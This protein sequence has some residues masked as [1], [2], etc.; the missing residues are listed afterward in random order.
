MIRQSRVGGILLGLTLC[1]CYEAP[2][3]DK[4]PRPSVVTMFDLDRILAAN[5]GEA[6]LPLPGGIPF[7][8]RFARVGADLIAKVIPAFAEGK[9]AAYITTEYWNQ[10]PEVWVQ[11]MY[12]LTTGRDATGRWVQTANAPIFSIA[13]VGH[14]G[15]T[16][17][18]YSPYWQVYYV[19]VPATNSK[20][21]RS[22]REI[23]ADK[24]PMEAG[25][26]RLCSLVPMNAT[27]E[28]KHP[29]TMTDTG[30]VS[31]GK[32]FVDGVEF[33]VFGFGQNRFTYN[34]TTREVDEQPL[35][36]PIVRNKNGGGPLLA[37]LPAVLGVRG[38]YQ[39]KTGAVIGDNTPN[40]GSLWRVY[41]VV[42]PNGAGVQIPANDTAFDLQVSVL[43]ASAGNNAVV[44][45]EQPKNEYTLRVLLN[46]TS[47]T[48]PDVDPGKGCR[49]LD[50]QDAIEST[51]PRGDIIDTGITANCPFV[52]YNGA[53][54][55]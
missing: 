17:A 55:K 27:V 5:P 11:P 31:I 50:S 1:A 7:A 20:V 24:L 49:W 22:V 8:G 48:A 41:L 29:I 26:P 51:V 6:T 15:K 44:R 19:T 40:F 10:I 4:G 16:S 43:M 21:Y 13:P 2:D 42:I 39:P 52:I 46:P 25:E 37:G 18:F 53:A 45:N 36:I 54:V 3:G 12:I 30:N 28:T 14:D 38:L 33:K 47:C 34:R 23:Y 9:L 35:F 32:G